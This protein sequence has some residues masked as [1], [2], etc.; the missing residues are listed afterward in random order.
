MTKTSR[1][2]GNKRGLF[3]VVPTE[4]YRM[5]PQTTRERKDGI[6]SVICFCVILVAT[7]LFWVLYWLSES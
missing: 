3:H 4:T 2:D 1:F 6:Y 7:G 5:A